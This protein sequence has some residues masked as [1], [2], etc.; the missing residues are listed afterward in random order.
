MVSLSMGESPSDNVDACR[1]D[2]W[3]SVVHLAFTRARQV[4]KIR[5]VYKQGTQSGS[6]AYGRKL[7]SPLRQA[8]NGWRGAAPGHD[9]DEGP[10]ARKEWHRAGGGAPP[11]DHGAPTQRPRGTGARLLKDMPWLP[12]NQH[13]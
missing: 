5:N 2:L 10:R 1:K 11:G 12:N 3:S 4:H 8:T 13:K 6:E 7:G 9:A